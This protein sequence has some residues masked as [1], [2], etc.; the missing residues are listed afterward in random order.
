MKH[1]SEILPPV[2]AGIARELVQSTHAELVTDTA[3]RFRP[4]Y[5]SIRTY[6]GELYWCGAN[7]N[8]VAR[9]AQRRINA[10]CLAAAQGGGNARRN[11]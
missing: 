11:L 6:S 1:I 8:R 4:R 7:D 10:P 5:P 9:D 3:G 2:M